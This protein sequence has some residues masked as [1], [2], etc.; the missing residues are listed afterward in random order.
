MRLLY[1]ALDQRY[2]ARWADRSTSRRSPKGSRR[3]VTTCTSRRSVAANRRRRHVA[4]DGAALRPVQARWARSWAVADLARRVG[5]TLIMERY[6]NFGG[7]GVLA[8]RRSASRPSSR[9][10]P[11]SWTTPAR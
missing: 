2:L 5:A 3:W 10:T 1:V 4:R 7:E 11:R 9:S 8:A 6:Y